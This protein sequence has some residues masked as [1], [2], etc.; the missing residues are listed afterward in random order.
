[1]SLFHSSSNAIRAFCTLSFI[2]SLVITS[3]R[4][5]TSSVAGF[6]VFNSAAEDVDDDDDDDDDLFVSW[7]V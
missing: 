7:Q 2:C 5:I 4:L 1:M 6:T 3:Y